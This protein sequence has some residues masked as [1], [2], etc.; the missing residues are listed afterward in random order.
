MKVASVQSS[1]QLAIP[2]RLRF[3]SFIALATMRLYIPVSQTISR[4]WSILS[5]R[6]APAD[7]FI[8]KTVGVQALFDLSRSFLNDAVADQ[9][10]RVTRFTQ[11]LEPA[12]RVDFSDSF[13][14]ASGASRTAIRKVLRI[15]DRPRS[16][17]A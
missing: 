6:H 13:F 7:T 16:A 15:R 12:Q 10:L 2:R 11:Q 5:A 17:V 9:D 1:N 14:H 8:R 4:Q 3:V